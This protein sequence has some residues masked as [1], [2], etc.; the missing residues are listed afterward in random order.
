MRRV[1]GVNSRRKVGRINEARYISSAGRVHGNAKSEVNTTAAEESGVDE[2]PEPDGLSFVTKTSLD[3][4]MRGVE[5][6]NRRRK[7]GR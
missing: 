1:E 4:V 7:V 3:A 6:A 2:R 5:G